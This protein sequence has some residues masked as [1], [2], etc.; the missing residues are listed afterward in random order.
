MG[1]LLEFTIDKKEHSLR[2]CVEYISAKFA[3]SQNEIKL[4]KTSG[5][6][7]I[8]SRVA[9]A[10]FCLTKAGLLQ[11]TN[12]GYF[13]ITDKGLEVVAQKPTEIDIAFLKYFFDD[14]SLFIDEIA[15][16]KKEAYLRKRIEK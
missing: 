7:L 14:L 1:P 11:C 15:L 13:K 16:K 4:Q 10:K 12:R 2:E 9:W 3:L 6:S 8:Y 5:G